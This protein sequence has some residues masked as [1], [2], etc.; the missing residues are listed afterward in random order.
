[1]PIVWRE[2]LS[3]AND[4]IDNDHKHLIALL[5]EI[6]RILPTKN[7]VKLISALDELARYSAIHF[8]REERTAKAAGYTQTATLNQSHKKLFDK[9]DEIR[10]EFNNSANEWSD[11]ASAHFVNFLRDW[12]IGHVIKEDLLMKPTFQKLSPSFCRI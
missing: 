9:F 7:R 12:L 1:M 8:D 6:E 10:T 5:N 3:V 4:M 2:Q 11:D